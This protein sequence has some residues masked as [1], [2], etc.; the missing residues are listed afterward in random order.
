LSKKKLNP[1]KFAR[2]VKQEALRVSW[3]SRRETAMS[4]AIVLIITF[5]ASLFFVTIDSLAAWI[6]QLILGIGR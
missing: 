3:P 1:A 2:E 6:I 4:A 5:V